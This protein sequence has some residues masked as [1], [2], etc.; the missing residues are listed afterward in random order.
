[1]C[2]PSP[3]TATSAWVGHVDR[4]RRGSATLPALPA[5]D[6]SSTTIGM[7]RSVTAA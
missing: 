2:Y 3:T 4:A 6:G 1:M 7:D 5:Q